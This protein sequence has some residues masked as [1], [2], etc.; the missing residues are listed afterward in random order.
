MKMSSDNF[1]HSSIL[2]I[3]NRIEK[4]QSNIIIYD[5][6]LTSATFLDYKVYEDF[7][8]FAAHSDVIIANR[9]DDELY[10]FRDKVF[11]RDIFNTDI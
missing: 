8:S 11:S 9:F 1:R 5:K 10:Q 7:E 6:N 4:T 2:G 3:I